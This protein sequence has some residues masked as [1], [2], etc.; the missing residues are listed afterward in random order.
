MGMGGGDPFGDL[1]RPAMGGR[2]NSIGGAGSG[3]GSPFDALFDMGMGGP[4]QHGGH[5]QHQ[6]RDPF[7]DMLAGL[8]MGGADGGKPTRG[9]Y[10]THRV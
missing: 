1:M 5:D 7:A 9:A 3:M 2:R 8:S 10:A 6:Q 4:G